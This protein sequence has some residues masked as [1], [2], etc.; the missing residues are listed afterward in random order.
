MPD[1]RHDYIVVTQLGAR[2]PDGSK[3]RRMLQA[4]AAMERA[5]RVGTRMGRFLAWLSA[6][7]ALAAARPAAMLPGLR[8]AAV[9]AWATGAG[10]LVIAA[11]CT[12]TYGR[13]RA[14]LLGE[15]EAPPRRAP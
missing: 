5:Q 6:P 15:L 3:L 12:W 1:E 2:D 7:L 8:A 14:L 13:K 9:A 11:L 4:Q 10:G